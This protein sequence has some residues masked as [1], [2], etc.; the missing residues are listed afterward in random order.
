MKNKKQEINLTDSIME[1]VKSDAVKM[2]PRLYFVAG[3]ILV[4]T[5]VGGF[6]LLALFFA[7]LSVHRFRMHYYLMHGFNFFDFPWIYLLITV[8]GLTAGIILLKKYDISY[9]KSL[10]AIAALITGIIILMAV[11]I[12]SSGFNDRARQHRQFM[13]FYRDSDL[14]HFPGHRKRMLMDGNYFERNFP[15]RPYQQ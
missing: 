3:T 12:D 10:L 6:L 8:I 11:V 14:E 7:N 1:K 15:R 9:K 2:H 13:R 4:G 5:G